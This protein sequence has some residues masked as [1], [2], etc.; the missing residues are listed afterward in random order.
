MYK[1]HGRR[2]V[3]ATCYAFVTSFKSLVVN[4]FLSPHSPGSN[5][6]EDEIEGALDSLR[7]F[8]EGKNVGVQTL[9]INIEQDP[10]FSFAFTKNCIENYVARSLL[11][12]IGVCSSC[13]EQL[14]L[15]SVNTDPVLQ[16]RDYRPNALLRPGSH[17]ILLFKKAGQ[18]LTYY[19]PKICTKNNAKNV[20]NLFVATTESKQQSRDA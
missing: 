14:L 16:F 18:V 3:N 17:F 6:E 9:Q 13:R 15:G 19:I 2:N 11:K 8:V 10:N 1:S 5:C 7:H 4:N 12:S 20:E